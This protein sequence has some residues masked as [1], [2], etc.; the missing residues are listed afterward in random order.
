MSR[1]TGANCVDVRVRCDDD[2]DGGG[3]CCRCCSLEWLVRR[4]VAG[5]T[6]VRRNATMRRNAD[7]N[8]LT[9][10]I[11]LSLA[12]DESSLLV[13]VVTESIVSYNQFDAV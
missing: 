11:F 9:E 8:A 2:D 3:C 1:G 12:R 5:E 10:I 6:E 7:A 13:M 4:R